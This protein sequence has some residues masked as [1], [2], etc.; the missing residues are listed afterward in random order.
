[1]INKAYLG[2]FIR[3]LQQITV[4]QPLELGN[5]QMAINKYIM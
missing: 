3:Y 4:R 2:P 1:M 5:P